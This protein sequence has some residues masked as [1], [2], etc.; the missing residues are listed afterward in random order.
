MS[1]IAINAVVI[2]DNRQ[3]ADG[4]CRMLSLLDINAQPAYGPRAAMLL[5][6]EVKPDIL[7]LDINMPGVDG[8][9]VLAYFRRLPKMVD[10]PVVIVTSD[11]QPETAEKALQSGAFEVIIKPV[12][13][14]GLEDV[15][16]KANFLK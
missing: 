5:L 13:L 8:F 7:F 3:M 16:Q 15:L 11:D 12:T 4:L 1:S 2:D 14:T 10:V 6:N 9:E